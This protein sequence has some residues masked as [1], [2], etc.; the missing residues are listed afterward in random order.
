MAITSGVD[1]K[2]S[3]LAVEAPARLSGVRLGVAQLAALTRKNLL[4]R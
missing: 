1:R 3:Q 2:T 4:I